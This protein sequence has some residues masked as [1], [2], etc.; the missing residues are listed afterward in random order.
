MHRTPNLAQPTHTGAPRCTRGCV[1]VPPFGRVAGPSRPCRRRK[2]PCRRR[3]GDRVVGAAP[4]PYRGLA[5]R[6][7]RHPTG[8]SPPLRS[9]YTLCVLQYNPAIQAAAVT[10]QCLYRDT[11]CLPS[12][13]SSTTIHLGVLQYNGPTNKPPYY[14]TIFGHCTPMLQYNFS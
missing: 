3:A 7:A 1:V 12:Q 5:G 4:V 9:R 6:V 11:A 8:Q 2:A 14:N 13:A 10:I